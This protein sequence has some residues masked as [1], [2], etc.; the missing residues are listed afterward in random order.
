[1]PV[2]C[3]LCSEIVLRKDVQSHKTND[4]QEELIDCSNNCEDRIKRGLLSK[5]VKDHCPETEI[6]CEN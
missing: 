3:D 5:H 6:S 1:M 4:C 2:K